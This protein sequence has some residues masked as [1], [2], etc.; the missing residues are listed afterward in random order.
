MPKIID[1]QK[2]RTELAQRAVEIFSK[3]GYS[4]LGMR[5][6]AKELGISKSALYHYF[7]TKEDLFTACTE[8]VTSFSEQNN[9]AH[10]LE[11]SSWEEKVQ[12]LIGIQKQIEPGF[13]GE[14]SL[15]VDYL[16]NKTV[17]EI[18]LDEN[19]KLANRRYLGLIEKFTS[20]KD[21]KP[22]LCLL[23]GAMLQRYFDGN[24][25]EWEEIQNWLIQQGKV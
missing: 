23:M 25:T 22:I 16:R 24:V 18:Q 13:P 4:G 20:S 7:P 8:V 10:R 19:M 12:E 17:I 14:L 6:I 2:Y 3:Y 15:L 5:T 9:I 21:A 1:H 11:N